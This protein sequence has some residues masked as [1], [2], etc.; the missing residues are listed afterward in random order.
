MGCP[1]I[2]RQYWPCCQVYLCLNKKVI[3]IL[4]I[5]NIHKKFRWEKFSNSNCSYLD[6]SN[7]FSWKNN[8]NL[9]DLI[10]ATGQVFLHKIGLKSLIFWPMWPGNL[11]E[12]NWSYSPETPN[13]VK[14]GDFV[15]PVM[16]KFDRWPWHTIGHLFYAT[17]SFVHHF[18][19]IREFKLELQSRNG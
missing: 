15:S 9:R 12:E 13:W 17:S 8:A 14:I 10:A 3:L 11:M 7:V 19:A 18:I 6:N 1:G 16:S 5:P 2:N 4:L